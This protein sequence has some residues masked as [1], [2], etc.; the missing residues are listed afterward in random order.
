MVED[1]KTKNKLIYKNKINYGT[2]RK[3][4]NQKGR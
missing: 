1:G 3:R 2:F 4:K